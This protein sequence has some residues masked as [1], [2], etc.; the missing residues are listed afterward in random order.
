[1]DPPGASSTARN[2]TQ[3][4]PGRCAHADPGRCAGIVTVALLLLPLPGTGARAQAAPGEVAAPHPPGRT[5]TVSASPIPEPK[6]QEASPEDTHP[7]RVLESLTRVRF[8]NRGTYRMVFR[9]RIRVN[10]EAGVRLLGQQVFPYSSHFEKVDV[11][12]VRVRKPDGRVITADTASYQDRAAAAVSPVPMYTD[13]R[14]LHVPVPSLR[15][16]DELELS[17]VRRLVEPVTP[18]HFWFQDVFWEG[19]PVDEEVIVADVPAGRSV[20]VSSPGV[21]PDVQERGDRRVYRWRHTVDPDAETD[22]EGT[23]GLALEGL[24]QSAPDIQ[25]TSF[26]GWSEVGAWFRELQSGRDELTP[27]IRE[28]AREL[29]RGARTDLER[30][31]ALHR[32]VATEVRY[33][34]VVLG[35]GRYQPHPASEVLRNGYGDCKDKHNL[36]SSLLRAV[37][38]EAYPALIHSSVDPD[39]EVPS[40]GQ[41]DHMVTV[42][43]HAD[44]LIW[45]DA[46]VG[47]APLGYLSS[48]LRGRDALIVFPDRE[49]RLLPAPEHL[50]FAAL[51]RFLMSGAVDDDGTLRGRVE[52]DY[53]G[54]QA[55]AL[56]NAFR[57]LPRTRWTDL[58]ERLSRLM[59][60]DAEI[61][62][63]EVTGVESARHPLGIRYA[64]RREGFL[65]WTALSPALTPPAVRFGLP[66][67]PEE[68]STAVGLGPRRKILRRTAIALPAG[69]SASPREG[70]S[71]ERPYAAFRS[72][73]ELRAD[74]VITERTLVVRAPEVP[75]EELDAYRSL[76][77]TIRL[78]RE[79]GFELTRAE[80][81]GSKGARKTTGD[82]SRNVAELHDAGYRAVERGDYQLAVRLLNMVVELAPDHGHAWNNLGWALLNLERFEEAKKAL[83]KQIALEPEHEYAYGNLGL[84]LEQQGDTAKAMS[85][86]RKALEIDPLAYEAHMGLGRLLSRRGRHDS[87]LVHLRQSVRLGPEDPDVRA[88]LGYTYQE[89]RHFDSAAVHFGKAVELRPDDPRYRNALGWSLMQS[90]RHADAVAHFEEALRLDPDHPRARGNLLRCYLALDEAVPALR[91]LRRI[92]DENPRAHQLGPLTPARVLVRDHDEE[93]VVELVEQAVDSEPDHPFFRVTL[94]S[95]LAYQGHY[96]SALRAME[97]AVQLESDNAMYWA[98]YGRMN[99]FTGD[100][101]GAREA[102]ARAMDL[103]PA[104]MESHGEDR[105][106]WEELSSEGG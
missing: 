15:P 1:M 83:R 6:G 50:P 10:S 47:P 29:T 55:V 75:P 2:V 70:V 103:D 106:I 89:L 90:G 31:R 8:T 41:F 74:S 36:L 79:K 105:E 38:L 4:D 3:V 9:S 73:Y 81:S 46:T 28:R 63:Q 94:A 87:A 95:L 65:D 61:R 85:A 43:P 39:P 37:G 22:P 57:N 44:S 12:Y 24:V 84:V 101:A 53:R 62:E 68:D 97:R 80:E 58:V 88:M 48:P 92:L 13:I 56:R 66:D 17:V 30:I 76:A 93:D 60:L 91:E 54:D 86:Y 45:V 5:S 64:V 42:I 33:V 7:Y 69:V 100:A 23:M 11:E 59:A 82:E 52:H 72:R 40:P 18:G 32:Y 104:Y 98:F 21:E 102:Y 71:M 99:Y 16:G 67:A 51:D 77:R 25:L 35:L 96:D 27:E 19:I 78:D 49:S 26:P 20:S 14:Q 34:A